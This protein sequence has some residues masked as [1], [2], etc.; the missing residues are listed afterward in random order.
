MDTYP[1]RAG[2]TE[3][4]T[5][6][7]AADAIE[8]SGKAQTLRD[9][10]VRVLRIEQASAQRFIATKAYGMTAD[11]IAA[12]LGESVFSIRP[13]VAELHKRGVIVKTGERRKSSNGRPSHVWRLV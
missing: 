6:K 5:S 10:V 2:F 12:E 7:D 4:T 8:D 11:E 1:T 3:H 13:R 9:E